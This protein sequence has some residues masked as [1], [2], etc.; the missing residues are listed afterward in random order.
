M[1]REDP[2]L[3]RARAFFSSQKGFHEGD[4]NLPGELLRACVEFIHM[5]LERNG[6]PVTPVPP[7]RPTADLAK[8]E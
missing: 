7:T 3:T 1:N 6:E 2:I 4:C 8:V 5:E